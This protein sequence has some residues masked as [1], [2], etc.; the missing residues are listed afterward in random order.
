MQQQHYERAIADYL[1]ALSLTQKDIKLTIMLLLRLGNAYDAMQQYTES[2]ERY[3]QALKLNIQDARSHYYLAVALEKMGY[4]SQAL[5]E[6]SHTIR[7]DPE[8]IGA[9]VNR[10]NMFMTLGRVKEAR[11]DYAVFFVLT[12]SESASDTEELRQY[13]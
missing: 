12:S 13:V 2:I 8:H 5:T 3:R 4:A 1:E 9:Y 11:Q 6:Y 10:G 7:L